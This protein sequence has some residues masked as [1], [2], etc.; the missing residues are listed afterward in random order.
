MS[1]ARLATLAALALLLAG[2]GGSEP[3]PCENLQGP[4]IEADGCF[5][6][7]LPTPSREASR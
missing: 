3:D 6:P 2:C 7:S 5:T 1:P 4:L